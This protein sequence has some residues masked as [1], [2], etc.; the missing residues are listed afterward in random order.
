MIRRY[1]S[2]AVGR[3]SEADATGGWEGSS[4]RRD[5]DIVPP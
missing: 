2:T 1:I 5:V 4:T 3:S